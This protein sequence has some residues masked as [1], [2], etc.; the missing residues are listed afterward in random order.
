[1]PIEKI[2]VQLQLSH[3]GAAGTKLGHIGGVLGLFI[4]LTVP[5]LHRQQKSPTFKKVS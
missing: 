1:M 2:H 3:T 4:G 5:S